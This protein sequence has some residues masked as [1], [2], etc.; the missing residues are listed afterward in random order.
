MGFSACAAMV[1][2]LHLRPDKSGYVG[3]RLGTFLAL[4]WAPFGASFVLKTSAADVEHRFSHQTSQRC[5]GIG[6][7]A[8]ED[9]SA[10]PQRHAVFE[11]DLGVGRRG[12]KTSAVGTGNQ[13]HCRRIRFGALALSAARNRYTDCANSSCASRNL[14]SEVNESKF[15]RSDMD[16]CRCSKDGSRWLDHPYAQQG[17]QLLRVARKGWW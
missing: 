7:R 6:W 5:P 14:C 12:E 17:P 3:P 10:Q 8:F 1:L 2:T 15:W 11:G 13:G 16:R 4:F 9:R